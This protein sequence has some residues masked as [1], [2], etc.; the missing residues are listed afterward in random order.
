[1]R[2]QIITDVE[3]ILAQVHQHPQKLKVKSEKN[4]LSFACPVCGDS[5]KD[6]NRK[7]AHIL[8]DKSEPYF[9]CHHEC[10]GMSMSRFY[11]HFNKEWKSEEFSFFTGPI[12]A[13]GSYRY[14]PKVMAM[15][16]ISRMSI[17]VYDVMK[18][19][20]LNNIK[21]DSAA[22]KYLERRNLHHLTEWMAWSEKWQRIC[23]FNPICEPTIKKGWGP[24]GTRYLRSM[25]VLGFQARDITGTQS[26]KYLTFSLEKIYGKMGLKWNPKPGTE[27]YIK[28]MSNTYYSTLINPYETMLITEGPLD[29]LLLPNAMAI[30]GVAKTNPKLDRNPLA[31]YIF[32]NDAS[33]RK[34]QSEQWSKHGDTTKI[35]D[36]ESIVRDFGADGIKDIND[37]WSH[38]IKT[39]H[40]FPDVKKYLI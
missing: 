33:G 19:F 13:K 16:E 15:H 26:A 37:L 6:M 34:K 3:Q 9:Y 28:L 2:E 1:M 35:F 18:Y 21:K 40:E 17:D 10:G 8:F 36:W 29:A 31:Q 12:Q 24:D 22:F 27:D 23:I 39:G 20:G 11:K 32:D 30:T 7:R 38:C 5:N 14:D 25:R 4:K